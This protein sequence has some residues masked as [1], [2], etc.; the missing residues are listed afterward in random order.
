MARGTWCRGCNDS[1]RLDSAYLPKKPTKQRKK[2]MEEKLLQ[3]LFEAKVS[4]VLQE[5]D[6]ISQEDIDKFNE[7]L[8]AG[9]WKD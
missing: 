2:K 5:E 7:A 8:M 3:M 6:R 9:E 4:F 1:G